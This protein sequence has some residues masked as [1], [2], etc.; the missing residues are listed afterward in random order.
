MCNQNAEDID[1]VQIC[2]LIQQ[3]ERLDGR[4]HAGPPGCESEMIR[5]VTII[6]EDVCVE[7]IAAGGYCTVVTANDGKAYAWGMLRFQA[8][9]TDDLV[10]IAADV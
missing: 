10:Q 4:D 6:D 1:I 3:S 7:S 2:M 5:Q 8:D 9:S